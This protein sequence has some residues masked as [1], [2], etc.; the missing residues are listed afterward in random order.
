MRKKNPL[1]FEEHTYIINR[2]VDYINENIT[3]DISLADISS[4]VSVSPSYLHR[5]FKSIV[6]ENVNDYMGRRKL[7]RAVHMLLFWD[8]ITIS[9][10][11]LLCGFSSLSAFSRSFK[12]RYQCSPTRYIE[13]YRNNKSKIR[14]IKDKKWERY[15]S[16]PGYNEDNDNS[17]EYSMRM[18]IRHFSARQGAYI[19]CYGGDHT[20]QQ[21]C[22]HFRRLNRTASAHRLWRSDTVLLGIPDYPWYM[23]EIRHSNFYDVCLSLPEESPSIPNMND[24][25]LEG[26][27]YAVIRIEEPQADFGQLM[28]ISLNHWLP[29]SGYVFD[30]RPTFMIYYNN[31]LRHPNQTI[32]AD[33][34]LPVRRYNS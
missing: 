18:A 16:S 2:A 30:T 31:P 28:M 7:E 3:S 29:S 20:T 24:R 5:M 14:Q 10:V 13:E 23:G 26:G 11:A 25:T 4:A 22:A 34:C 17:S 15:F 6:Q 9:E 32:I 33:F 12:L 1:L 21:L 19:R 27:D 8:G